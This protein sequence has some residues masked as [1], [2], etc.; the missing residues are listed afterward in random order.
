LQE[1]RQNQ[2]SAASGVAYG[3]AR[4]ATNLLNWTEVGPKRLER[5]RV[6]R[7]AASHRP[8]SW[9]AGKQFLN[10]LHGIEETM[11]LRGKRN[12]IVA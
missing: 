5:R 6:L 12:E 11:G 2:T 4:G 8:K 10:G 9:L 1:S 3:D 7:D